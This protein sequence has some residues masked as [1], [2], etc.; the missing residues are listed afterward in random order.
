[1]INNKLNKINNN[2]NKN[3][4]IIRIKKDDIVDE[5]T[6]A[7]LVSTDEMQIWLSKTYLF[8]NS[9]TEDVT[10]YLHGNWTFKIHL[11]EQNTVQEVNVHY[12][13]NFFDDVEVVTDGK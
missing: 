7:V 12:L 2:L 9:K 13:T 8:F 10:I 4:Y 3:K 5:T 6:K 1:M 11:Y